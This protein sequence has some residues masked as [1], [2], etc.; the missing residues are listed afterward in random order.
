MRV[1]ANGLIG[2]LVGFVVGGFVGFWLAPLIWEYSY[3]GVEQG[4]D[5]G[6]GP[7]VLIG[8]ILFSLVGCAIGVM[9]SRRR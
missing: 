5:Y 9:L 4:F 7:K 2:L 8:A 3:P 1:F 6:R